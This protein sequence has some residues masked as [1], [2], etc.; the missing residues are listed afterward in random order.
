MNVVIAS[1]SEDLESYRTIAGEMTRQ[2][3][4]EPSMMNPQISSESSL[5]E[6]IAPASRADLLLVIVGWRRDALPSP[7][8]GGD[9]RRSWMG[10]EVRAALRHAR[11]VVVLMADESWPMESRE[12]NPVARAWL[13][14]FRGDFHSTAS[15]F[16]PEDGAKEQFRE[17]V[18]SHLL[19]FVEDTAATGVIVHQELGPQELGLRLRQW[20]EPEFPAQPFPLLLPYTHPKLLTGRERERTELER[21]LRLPMPILGLYA[22]SGAGKS[23]LLWGALVPTLRAAGQPV[24]FVRHPSESG[25][26]ERLI[27]DFL[28]MEDGQPVSQEDGDHQ[29]F[30]RRLRAAK[31]LAGALPVLVIDQ[32]EDVL[33]TDRRQT[34]AI[35]G[36]LLAASIQRQVGFERGLCRW[37]LAYRQEFHGEV[38]RWLGDV[39]WEARALGFEVD[40][41]LPHDLAGSDRFHAFSLAPLGTA[42]GAENSV[43]KA[44]QVFRTVI[45]TPLALRMDDGTPRYRLRFLGDG[46]ARLAQAFGEARVSQPGA[47]LVPE[48]QV[49]LA[50]V[51]ERATVS[52]ESRVVEIPENPGELIAQALQEHVQRALKRAFPGR[53]EAARIGRTRALLALRELADV[54]GQ[55]D[56]GLA[57]GELARAIGHAGREVLEKL[58]TPSTRLVVAERHG[59]E[60]VYV[61]SHDR[62]A[63]VVVRLVDGEDGD[64]EFGIDAELLALRRFVGLKSE[65]FAAGELEPATE[66]PAVFFREIEKHAAAL[67]W[68]EER[69]RWWEA[70][71]IRF[72]AERRRDVVRRIVM[73]ATLLVIVLGVW[74][75]TDLRKQRTTLFDEVVLGDPEAAF[76]AVNELTVQWNVESE[77]LLAALRKRESPLDILE[78][79]IGGIAVENDREGV[80]LRVAELVLPL[81]VDDAPEDPVRIA[82]LVWALD[83]FA[84]KGQRNRELRDQALAALREKYPPPRLPAPS[85][86]EGRGEWADIPAGTF[87]M[88]AGQ[89]E[90]RDDPNMADEKP[91]HQVTLSAFRLARHEV[92]NVEFRRLYPQHAEDREDRRPAVSMTWH[93][94]YTYAAWLGGRLPTEAEAEYVR[95]GGCSFTY[96]KSDGSAATLDEVAW[97]VGNSVDPETGEPRT[98]PVG[99]LE[100]NPWGLF[101]LYGNVGELCA[102][103]Y[104]ESYSAADQINPSGGTDTATDYR[105]LRGGSAWTPADWVVA[106]GRGVHPYGRGTINTGLRVLLLTPAEK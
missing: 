36:L 5:A 70:S 74:R 75:W 60:W 39:L 19:Q 106:S 67:L 41:M 21:K 34:R 79:G 24:A 81:I 63:A 15:F 65:L 73:V 6:R 56:A 33:R 84:S 16:K 72:R 91:Q 32:F 96:C 11:P 40:G 58:S 28:K 35:F 61:L 30:A 87:L 99:E 49:V 82:N 29:A 90:G 18:R 3:G 95:R 53:G 68:G 51:L 98:W 10:W 105:V 55:R 13:L 78:R 8:L 69:Q 83:F 52:A 17:L 76:S 66:I 47:P 38:V 92:T 14:D 20:P 101:D 7:E 48:L 4:F 22:A 85:S 86:D 104:G 12:E 102:D 50:H 25:L 45:E 89:D 57:E 1:T 26:G 43:E 94:A 9:G 23:S 97:W 31:E 42:T 88:G 103:W 44:A 54:H 71:R 27:N 2:L 62:L 77:E 80:V 100:P 59:E 46:A 64:A 93:E 37:L